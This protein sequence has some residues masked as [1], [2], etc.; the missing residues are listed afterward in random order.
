MSG[1]L[2]SMARR[3]VE[4]SGEIRP[5]LA[6][7]FEPKSSAE[8]RSDLTSPGDS[9][10][11]DPSGAEPA[12]TAQAA[13][14]ARAPGTPPLTIEGAP[15][16]T[17]EHDVET[18]RPAAR[19]P[20]AHDF[21]RAPETRVAAREALTLPQRASEGRVAARER[22]GHPRRALA[23]EVENARVDAQVADTVRVPSARDP[24]APLA[25]A[26]DARVNNGAH[27]HK[28]AA[29][30]A[31]LHSIARTIAIP[32]SAG[33]PRASVPTPGASAPDEPSVVHVSIGRIEVRAQQLQSSPAVT[34]RTEPAPMTLAEY[35]RLRDAGAR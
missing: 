18:R 26:P 29:R 22:P 12:T 21:E 6:S 31:P 34:P 28:Q 1:F 32:Q 25:P 35:L 24:A 23:R 10:Q 4:P 9:L 2:A 3:V 15:P 5:R 11:T 30:P 13:A 17:I 14:T 7:P 20:V 19:A 27:P 33:M 16:S 8:S